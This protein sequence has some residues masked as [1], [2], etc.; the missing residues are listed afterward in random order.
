[1]SVVDWGNQNEAP[2][3]ELWKSA[4]GSDVWP[5]PLPC[6]KQDAKDFRTEA[7]ILRQ[8]PQ[9]RT[10]APYSSFSQ[11]IVWYGPRGADADNP[12]AWPMTSELH[13]PGLRS[14]CRTYSTWSGSGGVKSL[15]NWPLR[16]RIDLMTTD[17]PRPI[18]LMPLH[19]RQL[20][21][22]SWY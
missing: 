5:S 15:T 11:R 20:T 10:Q 1:M 21:N 2:G 4:P 7:G 12:T 19:K 6:C 16:S 22:P 3:L 17:I 9:L 8:P 18:S 14:R 13:D